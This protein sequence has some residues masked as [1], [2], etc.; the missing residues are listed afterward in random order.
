M[1]DRLLTCSAADSCFSAAG[2]VGQSLAAAARVRG[3]PLLVIDLSDEARIHELYGAKYVLVRPDGHVAW[4]DN[5]QPGSPGPRIDVV[6]GL[7]ARRAGT[8]LAGA[9]HPLGKE[10]AVPAGSAP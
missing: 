5:A 2:S 3:F 7:A 8:H 10:Q 9:D 4:R 6:R 1:A